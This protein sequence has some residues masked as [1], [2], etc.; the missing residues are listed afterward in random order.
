MSASIFSTPTA[1]HAWRLTG[2]LLLCCC[3]Q[4]CFTAILATGGVGAMAIHDRRSVGVQTDDE[5]LEWKAASRIPEAYRT[6]AH[7]N[8]TA[9]NRRLLV[10]GEAPNE[11]A[12]R[13]IISALSG[14][15]LRQIIDELAIMPAASFGSRGKD[16]LLDAKVKARLIEEKQLSANHV[17]VVAERGNIYLMGL[18]TAAEAKVA[19]EVASTTEGVLKVISIFEVLSASELR[20]ANHPAPAK[21]APVENR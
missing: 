17:K 1:S 4:G 6:S 5:L 8:F 15:D 11:Q 14:L 21:L 19:L 2:A 13:E 20:S 9:F 18:V 12:R 10:T 3:L 7:V 16:S